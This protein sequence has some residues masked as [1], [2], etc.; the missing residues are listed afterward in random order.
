[1]KALRHLGLW[2]LMCLVGALWLRRD[3]WGWKLSWSTTRTPAHVPFVRHVC[4]PTDELVALYGTA[5]HPWALDVS[6]SDVLFQSDFGSALGA[7]IS[8]AGLGPC[9]LTQDKPGGRGRSITDE[10][11]NVQQ[12]GMADAFAAFE[13][14]AGFVVN[15]TPA[16]ACFPSGSTPSAVA[17]DDSVLISQLT[18][19]GYAQVTVNLQWRPNGGIMVHA[20]DQTLTV[21]NVGCTDGE[22]CNYDASAAVDDGSCVFGEELDG[23]GLVYACDGTCLNDA[24]SMGCATNLK[25]WGARCRPSTSIRKPQKTTVV[26]RCRLHQPRGRQLRRM[27]HGK[28]RALP[29]GCTDEG[30]SSI[31]PQRNRERR[32]LRLP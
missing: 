19:S 29:R 4:L 8:A 27:G 18:L 15:R 25:S 12:A 10:A 21:E 31:Q 28:R 17:G 32:K 5:N 2:V 24:D 9:G 3:L 30:S 26:P 1:M 6:G 16:A 11:S 7:D 14:G 23:L 13:A 22:A 20:M